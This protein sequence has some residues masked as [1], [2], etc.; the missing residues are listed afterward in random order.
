MPPV[1]TR[2]ATEIV[3]GFVA[4]RTFI[5]QAG[6]PLATSHR[7]IFSRMDNIPPDFDNNANN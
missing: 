1:R 4:S 5:G 7:G 6:E 3:Y 2:A